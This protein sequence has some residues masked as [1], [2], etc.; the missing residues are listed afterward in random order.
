MLPSSRSLKLGM[1]ILLS[2][3]F[4]SLAS[5][6]CEVEAHLNIAEP[7]QEIGRIHGTGASILK[8]SPDFYLHNS[9]AIRF[10]CVGAVFIVAGMLQIQRSHV[11]ERV[12]RLEKELE[13]FRKQMAAV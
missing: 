13:T 8:E 3:L 4:F 9:L 12:T 2:G 11:S 5:A 10:F 7:I 1:L 6:W